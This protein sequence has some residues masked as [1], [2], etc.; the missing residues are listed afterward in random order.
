MGDS[1]ETVGQAEATE[2]PAE[3]AETTETTEASDSSPT[4]QPAPAE[5]E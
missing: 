1:E 2:S 4:E 3:V 5:G